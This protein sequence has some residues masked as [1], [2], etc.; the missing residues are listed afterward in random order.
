MVRSQSSMRTSL[1]LALLAFAW[2]T[3]ALASGSLTISLQDDRSRAVEGTATATPEGGG[4]AQS[5]STRGGRCS[6]TG[7]QAGRYRVSAGL[8]R[9]GVTPTSTV[10]VLEGRAASVRLTALPPPTAGTV[11]QT[12]GG[13]TP[14]PPP[15][16]DGGPAGGG[17]HGAGGAGPGGVTVRPG[18]PATAQGAL[19]RG[20][21]PGVP[22]RAPGPIVVQQAGPNAQGGAP[23]APVGTNQSRTAAA[24]NLGTGQHAAILGRTQDQRGRRVEG[25]VTVQQGNQSI[26]TVSTTGGSF[27]AF[28]LPPGQ[29]SLSFTALTGQR[30][31]GTVTVVQGAAAS[32]RLTVTR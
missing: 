12:Q 6:I 15:V 29:Y 27:T 26:G 9:G 14:A 32:V 13:S 4:A 7:L 22:G 24:R 25:S 28:D 16:P 20:I 10:T 21:R 3:V 2:P 31:T 1:A 17:P 8:V 18:G 19:V 5:C 30:T 23:A 11:R